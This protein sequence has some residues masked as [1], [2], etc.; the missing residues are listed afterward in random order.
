M[1]IQC[2]SKRL[3]ETVDVMYGTG[4]WKPQEIKEVPD[5]IG[6]K[7]VHHTDVYT[8]VSAIEDVKKVSIAPPDPDEPLQEMRDSLRNMNRDQLRDFIQAKFDVKLDMR[9]YPNEDG[10]RIYATMLIDQYGVA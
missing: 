10:L 2:V 9:K 7:M 8:E 5:D 4:A 3:P 1:N 6:K